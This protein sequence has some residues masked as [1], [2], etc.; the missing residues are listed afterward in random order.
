MTN[1][2]YVPTGIITIR[3]RGPG[4]QTRLRKTV[5]FKVSPTVLDVEKVEDKDIIIVQ[6]DGDVLLEESQ[7]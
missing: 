2:Y 1:D 6:L 4:N 7:K 5:G 3:T